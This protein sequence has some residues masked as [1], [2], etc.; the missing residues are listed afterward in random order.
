[1]AKTRNIVSTTKTKRTRPA[2]TPEARENQLIAKAVAL[3]EKQLD[4]GSASSQIVT[5]YLK[6]GTAKAQLEL[7]KLKK[8]TEMIEAKTEA[9]KSQKH[10]EELYANALEAM[11]SYSG[12][13]SY[14]D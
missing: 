1:M 2:L 8:E 11:R 13:N 9:L 10:V 14:D 12:G 7:Q 4:D 6:L 3:A 5:H